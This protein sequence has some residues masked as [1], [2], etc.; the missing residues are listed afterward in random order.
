MLGIAR[1]KLDGQMRLVQREDTRSGTHL[2]VLSLNQAPER[3]LTTDD[4]DGKRG[5]TV[6]S[7]RDFMQLR[8]QGVV[9][10][11]SR[12]THGVLVKLLF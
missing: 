7:H 2:R 1:V 4:A 6:L 5:Y 12:V 9:Q 11:I 10:P 3:L 8:Y